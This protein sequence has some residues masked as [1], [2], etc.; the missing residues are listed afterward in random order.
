MPTAI[1]MRICSTLTN[2]F[3]RCV[4]PCYVCVA[5][6]CLVLRSSG[7]VERFTKRVRT[8]RSS[9]WESALCRRL[10]D[11]R[12]YRDVN[13]RTQPQTLEH[14][15][16]YTDCDDVH[17]G[18]AL[19]CFEKLTRPEHAGR[20][21]GLFARRRT[22]MYDFSVHP[23][24]LRV[25]DRHG[26]QPFPHHKNTATL[27]SRRASTFRTTTRHAQEGLWAGNAYLGYYESMG[28]SSPSLL[29]GRPEKLIRMCEVARR[30]ERLASQLAK[31]CIRTVVPGT[32]YSNC[33]D[34][35]S[36]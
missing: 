10:L 33:N 32:R 1:K 22:D 34:R 21:G 35:S 24:P 30:W 18:P 17:P 5:T 15:Y 36:W 11:L 8:P 27:G 26:R 20:R 3:N 31:L 12:S 7:L 4:S 23:G 13:F 19:C 2:D 16:I 9:V 6:S 29:G 28:S 25:G 14:C